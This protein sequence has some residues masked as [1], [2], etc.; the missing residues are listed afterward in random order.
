MNAPIRLFD[1]TLTLLA[2]IDDYESAYFARK[3][4]E[5]GEFNIVINK[6]K[7]YA[8]K[9]DRGV[10]VM[11]AGH[12]DSVGIITEIEKSVDEGGH[13]SETIKAKGYEFKYVFNWRNVIPLAGKARYA[14]P[15][16]VTI[17][18][19]T[20]NPIFNYDFK[21]SRVMVGS[22]CHI[23]YSDGGTVYHR[24][25][26]DAL[27]HTWSVGAATNLTTCYYPS[28]FRY[29][30]IFYLIGHFGTEQGSMYIYTSADGI[31]WTVANG[32]NP[33]FSNSTGIYTYTWSMSIAVIGSNM[34]FAVESADDETHS[35]IFGIAYSWD[36]FAHL[37]AGT[38]NFA[39]NA[40]ATHIIANGG[41]P[42][43]IYDQN[44]AALILMHS[45]INYDDVTYWQLRTAWAT[46]T[47]SGTYWT[48]SAWTTS[49]NW[50]LVVDS[51]NLLYPDFLSLPVDKT[52]GLLIGYLYDS[53]SNY[54]AYFDMTLDEFYD[55]ISANISAETVM[56]QLVYDQCGLGA[57]SA[58]RIPNMTIATLRKEI[59]MFFP[60]V[61]Q[62]CGMS[63][64]ILRMPL[65]CRL[66]LR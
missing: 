21:V 13:G 4:Y 56:K 50:G 34:Y 46:L 7:L 20:G 58:R 8:S 1:D 5:Y 28:V 37:T 30:G 12:T 59:H 38:C 22:T 45:Y 44:K 48:P 29:G 27:C 16:D 36:S 15:G 26:T 32:G 51:I 60:R 24:T 54:Q 39:T 25:A 33:V 35:N 17:I 52:Y 14:I 61:I 23:F 55:I 40:S 53:T 47:D 11:V 62:K 18:Q 10:I 57:D 41:S 2:E 43:L 66:I 49:N 6:N 3:W 9:L 42:N 65:T 19:D 31:T 64:M 63:C